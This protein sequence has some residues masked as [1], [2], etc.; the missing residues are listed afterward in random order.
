MQVA[1]FEAAEGFQLRAFQNAKATALYFDEALTA[2]F[3]QDPVHM[4]R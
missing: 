1:V 2:Q 4:D 3:L